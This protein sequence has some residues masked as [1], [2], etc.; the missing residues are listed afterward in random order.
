MTTAEPTPTSAAGAATTVRLVRRLPAHRDVVFRA[1]TD[2]E[3]LAHWFWPPRFV[4]EVRVDLRVG[5]TFRIR[6]TGLPA[7]ENMGVVGR[8]LEVAVPERVRYTWRWEGEDD[9]T[10]VTVDFR[11]AGDGTEVE[12]VHEGFASADERDN[13]AQGWI[14]CLDRLV[15]T[16]RG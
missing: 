14:D 6:S 5:G 8:F 10:V 4:T 16:I 13:H 1:W 3:R 9:E 7:G 12:L 2:A 15:T 11:E